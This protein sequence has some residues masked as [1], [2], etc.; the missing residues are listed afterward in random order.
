MAEIRELFDFGKLEIITEKTKLPKY[1]LAKLSFSFAKADSENLNKRTY[2]ESILAR[3][4]NRKNEELQKAKI[5]GMLDH[6]FGGETKLAGSMHAISAMDYSRHTKL[7]SAESFVLNTSK[8]RD[9][10]TLLKS[11]IKL[12]ASMRGWGNLRADRRVDDD[13]KLET[14]DFVANPSFGPDA[15]IDA[16]NLIESYNPE[17]VEGGKKGGKGIKIDEKNIELALK[18]G[19]DA[20]VNEFGYDKGWE[21]YKKENLMLTT[22][23]WLLQ[24][25]EK[26]FKNI[27][28]ALDYLGS[29][30]LAD[31]Y[32]KKIDEEEQRTEPYTSAE[33]YDEA[34]QAG[35]HPQEMAD[36]LNEGLK[37]STALN[38][39]GITA[40]ERQLMEE[41]RDAGAKGA[42]H[43][44]L[45]KVRQM[46]KM[47]KVFKP[48]LTEEQKKAEADKKAKE[49][50]E[51]RRQRIIYQVNRDI[52]AAGG[53]SPEKLKALVNQ[54]LKEE[55]LLDE[56]EK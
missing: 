14:V 28:A 3:E 5:A 21:F 40:K 53:T 56:D 47:S 23:E 50:R 49:I 6:P 32:I 34:R 13:Y 15:Q 45:E 43:E 4:V 9:F 24:N 19:Y 38:N 33:V 20:L 25:Y 11:G 1:A 29:G 44:L 22:A 18:I 51:A 27:R 55:G 37:V 35:I 54:A 16:S 30:H 42:P 31:G 2:P 17:A 39:A 10:M 26:K 46:E 36:K 41:L 8:G 7:A 52:M 48:K 12:G